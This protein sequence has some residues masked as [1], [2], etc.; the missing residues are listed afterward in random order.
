MTSAKAEDAT[1]SKLL[2]IKNN[3][4][5][6]PEFKYVPMFNVFGNIEDDSEEFY[7]YYQCLAPTRE[8]QEQHLEQKGL[9][10]RA[11]QKDSTGNISPS[12]ENSLVSYI[13]VIERKVKDQIQIFEA[14]ATLCESEK[15]GLVNL[16]I[17]AKN[18]SHI[19]IPIYNN[20][21]DIIEI[22]E[23]TIIGYL[24]TKIEDQPSNTI[25][26][27]SQLC[28]YVD[29]TSQTIYRWNECYLLQSE[30]LKQINMKNLDPLQ[31][32]QLKMLLNNFTDIFVSKNEFGRTDIIQYQIKTGNVMPI[33]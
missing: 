13:V 18:Y 27:F 31:H 32:I 26:D 6:L 19:K 33:K 28:K 10:Y 29:I 5:T 9:Y 16:H 25:S 24:I 22:P 11:K 1:I 4:L 23:G 12:G 14:E 20:M 2:E 3:L 8:E 15:I 30:Q 21:G 17:P 7:E